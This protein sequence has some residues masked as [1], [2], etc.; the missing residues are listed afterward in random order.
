M[1]KAYQVRV[2]QSIQI[3]AE[4]W[5]Y[6]E[7]DNED[8]AQSTAIDLANEN[9][10]DYDW[11]NVVEDFGCDSEVCEFYETGEEVEE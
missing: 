7:A 8:E 6:V 2:S 11:D 4:A 3:Q 1:T 9:P 5:I 10:G